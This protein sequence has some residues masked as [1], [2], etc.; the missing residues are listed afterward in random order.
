M[1]RSHKE[2]AALRDAL[3]AQEATGGDCSNSS[4]HLG[5]GCFSGGNVNSNTNF[6]SAGGPIQMSS[7][8]AGL[9]ADIER[10]I[11]GTQSTGG[12]QVGQLGK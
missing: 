3:I 7:Q 9:I 6:S 11:R 8:H 5:I 12:Q 2:E 4:N 1:I 10:L